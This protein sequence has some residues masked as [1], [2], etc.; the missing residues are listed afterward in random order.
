MRTLSLT[1]FA[2]CALFVLCSCA[3]HKSQPIS[4]P[5]LITWQLNFISGLQMPLDALYPEKPPL[6]IFNSESMMVHGY[7]GC[8]DFSIS[9]QVEG[10]GL[11]FSET[12]K[13]TRKAC[14]G[15]GADFFMGQLKAVDSFS[16]S[17]NRLF[18]YGKKVPLM[19]FVKNTE[20]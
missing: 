18:L 2:L 5:D 14:P 20:L 17:E 12:G 7:N 19:R 6:I 15:P 10:N 13:Q 9:Y 16:V 11:E 8:N 4:V 3:G 1:T